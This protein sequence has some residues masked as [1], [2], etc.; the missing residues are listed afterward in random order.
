[1]NHHHP[2]QRQQQQLQQE[3]Q[4][5]NEE[6]TIDFAYINVTDE[7]EVDI[8]LD[9]SSRNNHNHN[10]AQSSS[11]SALDDHE[12]GGDDEKCARTADVLAVLLQSQRQ[13]QQSPHQG[14]LSLVECTERANAAAVQ[15]H[16]AKQDGRLQEALDRHTEAAQLFHEAAVR[17]KECD[18]ACRAFVYHYF[19]KRIDENCSFFGFA[20]PPFSRM[21]L[22]FF[23]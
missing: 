13:Q 4:H 2:Q 18:G 19:K 9:D 22:F 3:P 21:R 16:D 5:D 17:V 11:A 15:A 23:F 1:M 20:V 8:W 6:T 12:D 14:R 7:D 10:A